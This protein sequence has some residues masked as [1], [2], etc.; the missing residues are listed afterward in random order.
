MS[1]IA[2]IALLRVVPL[3]LFTTRKAEG[4]TQVRLTII[5]IRI[6]RTRA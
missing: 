4:Q 5:A 6:L 1:D 3:S 2:C